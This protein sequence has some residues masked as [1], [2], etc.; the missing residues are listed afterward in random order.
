M[1]RCGNCGSGYSIQAAA[2]WGSCPRCL[3]RTRANIPLSYEPPASVRQP[4]GDGTARLVV[5]PDHA[6]IEQQHDRAQAG[7][8]SET[9]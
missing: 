7:D 2:S 4:A 1:Y 3:A 9:G 6:D 5:G 8:Y